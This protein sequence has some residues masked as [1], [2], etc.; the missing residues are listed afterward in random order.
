[1]FFVLACIALM[2]W[3]SSGTAFGVSSTRSV[4]R[5]QR[6][7]LATL[8]ERDLTWYA[9]NDRSVG[10]LMSAF[11]KDSGD[12][13]CLSGPVLG[14]I[15]TTSTS[16]IGGMVLAL[17]VAWKIAVVLL[18][19]VPVVLA[20][21]YTRLQVLNSADNRRRSAYRTATSFAVQACQHRPTVAVYRLE[22]RVLEKYHGMLSLPFKKS[23]VFMAWSNIL[24]AAS[25]AITYF[26]YA[27]A[28]WWY[29][30]LATLLVF[31][32]LKF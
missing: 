4:G 23:Q 8:L 13:S 26:V 19:A 7:L 17:V 1:M 25:F 30:P 32:S 6:R 29:V 11:T 20:A 22:N 14:T 5:I 16:M 9:G 24:L 21:G 3:V 2:A 31:R 27:L 18:A 15:F 28:Y 10:Q 12:L